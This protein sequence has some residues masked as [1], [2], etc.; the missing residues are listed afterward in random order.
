MFFY[1]RLTPAY[2][3]DLTKFEVTNRLLRIAPHRYLALLLML[4]KRGFITEIR[5]DDLRR[6]QMRRHL[7][8][9]TSPVVYEFAPDA[10]ICEKQ[11]RVYADVN[12]FINADDD[13]LWA[14][15]RAAEW[16]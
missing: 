15:A 10:G 2:D 11:R 9:D 7:A 12:A 14:R 1:V 3:L 5:K 13:T 6:D 4:I 8:S 16:P